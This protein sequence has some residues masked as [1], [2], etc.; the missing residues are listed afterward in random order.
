MTVSTASRALNRPE[1]V[2]PETRERV[3][4]AARHLGYVPNRMARAIV[5]GRSEVIVFV[6]PDLSLGLFST[7]ASAAQVE[8]RARK[9]DLLVADSMG[10]AEREAGLIDG[11]R[12]YAEGIILLW[13]A[14]DY[15][16]AA[17][18]PPVVS[19]GRRVRGAHAV[20]LDQAHVIELQ[21]AHLR[22]LGHEHILWVDG[23]DRFWANR[24][25]RRHAQRLEIELGITISR[26]VEPS[27]EGGLDLADDLD[28]SIT[29]VAAF[30]D[31]QALGIV[32]RLGERG[33]RVPHD[34][35]VIGNNDVMWARMASPALTTVHTP[36]RSMGR[37]AV[38]LLLDSVPAPEGTQIVETLQS[39]LVVRNST[40][41]PRA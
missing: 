6:V 26:Q 19:I 27:F 35:S 36:F 34:V 1:L 10:S 24:D 11:A 13:P 5:T 41:P 37:A 20:L 32:Q 25:R 21:V 22:E 28:P 2:R 16:P 15:E 38:S 31:N 33:I 14:A 40:A 4:A 3:T 12:A 23:P 18:D 9:Y 8:A 17:D 39:R 7:V 30:V 29:A